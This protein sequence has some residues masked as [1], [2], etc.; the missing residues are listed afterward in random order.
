MGTE[1]PTLQGLWWIKGNKLKALYPIVVHGWGS[2]FLP[3]SS[4]LPCP[5]TPQ[6]QAMKESLTSSVHSPA[7][8]FARDAFPF[9]SHLRSPGLSLLALPSREEGD[10]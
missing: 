1:P 7:I 3:P 5:L 10:A 6:L 9:P 4:A 8:L 2:G